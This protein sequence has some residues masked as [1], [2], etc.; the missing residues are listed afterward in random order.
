MAVAA[1]RAHA[2]RLGATR[3][4]GGASVRRVEVNGQAG[5]LV[6]DRAGRLIGVMALEIAEGHVHGVRSIVN[7]DKL[8][9]VGPVG[10]L[11]AVL[12][13]RDH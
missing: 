4:P 3:R 11:R 9:H 10:D 12:A 8:R 1:W 2:A 6:L 5:A 7:P 13:Q